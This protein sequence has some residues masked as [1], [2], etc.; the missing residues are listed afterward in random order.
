MARD[1]GRAGGSDPGRAVGLRGRGA[2]LL[3]ASLAGCAGAEGQPELRHEGE[4]HLRAVRQLTFGGQNAEAYFSA[5]DRWLIFQA[6]PPGADCDQQYIMRT[7]G[8]GLRRISTGEGR[9]TCGYIFPGGERILYASTHL[10]SPRC[11]PPP[12]Y[13]RG[14]VWALYPSYDIFSARLDGSDLARLTATPGYDAEATVSR[15]GRWI[16]FTSVRDGDLEIYRM[17][18]DGSDPE[19]LTHEEGYDGGAFYS[20]DGTQIVYRAHHPEGEELEEYRAL[21]AS[22]LVRPSRLEIFVMNADGSGKRQVTDN[23]AANFSPYFFPD[24]RRILFASNVHDPG[25][26]EFDLYAIGTDG[27]G[28]ERVTFHPDFDG[29]PMFDSSGARLVWAS[30]RAGSEPGETNIFIAEWVE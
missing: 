25:G 23:G 12:D 27:V 6:T 7:D 20:Y 10:E 30:N 5:D 2:A 3:L 9:T 13:S 28:L 11:P 14:Y 4:T 29:F 21:L 8:S 15:D 16:V 22:D 19:R 18:P 17:R 24:G 26:R 1:R